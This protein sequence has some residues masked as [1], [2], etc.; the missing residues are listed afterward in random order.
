VISRSAGKI[1]DRSVEM[2]PPISG[3]SSDPEIHGL[4]L[5]SVRSAPNSGVRLDSLDVLRGQA[6]DPEVRRALLGSMLGDH[7]PGV[8]LKALDALRPHMADPEVRN[9]LVGCCADLIR[10]ARLCHR[11]AR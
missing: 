9:A 2:P 5:A 1:R 8:R 10:H 7:N 11:H 3:L 6:E 4:L